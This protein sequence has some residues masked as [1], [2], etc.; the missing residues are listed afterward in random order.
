[1]SGCFC[2]QLIQIM[3]ILFILDPL[4]KLNKRWDNSLRVIGELTRRGHECFSADTPDFYL[5]GSMPGAL[6]RPLTLKGRKRIAEGKPYKQQ[7]TS[8]DLVVIRKE[9][10][11]DQNFIAMTRLL[12]KI[13]SRIPVINAPRALREINEK[14][15]ILE[16]P[17]WIPKTIVTGSVEAIVRFR[18]KFKKPIVVK[19]LDQKGGRGVFILDELSP[20][21]LSRV[22]RAA[23]NGGQTLMAQEFIKKGSGEKRIVLLHG[24]VFCHYEKRARGNEFRA[25]LSLGAT[26][27]KVPLTAKEKE[28]CLELKPFL[29]KRGLEFVGIDVLNGKL[30][31]INVTS[32]A[33]VTEAIFLEPQRPLVEA[34]ADFLED[35]SQR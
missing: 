17:R 10:P 18:K 2:L 8:F 27:H 20:R 23:R 6:C 34:W 19:P 12:E 26:F 13:E 29:L 14:L 28:L 24:E 25:N 1:M 3:K 35:F 15:S 21:A 32:P 9:P 33:G 31:E 7:I 5:K 4:K 11:V 22:K 30:I 16:F